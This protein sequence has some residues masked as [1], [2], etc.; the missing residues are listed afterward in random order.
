MNTPQVKIQIN[1][2]GA[3][4][5]FHDDLVE[6]RLAMALTG[7]GTVLADNRKA[8]DFWGVMVC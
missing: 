7:D 5:K 2:N 4:T 8:K 3:C 6:V 1:Q